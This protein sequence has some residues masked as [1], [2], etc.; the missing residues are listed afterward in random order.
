M[1]LTASSYLKMVFKVTTIGSLSATVFGY[2]YLQYINSVIGSISLNKEEAIAFYKEKY[3][4][5]EKQ[6][7]ATYYYALWNLS[8]ARI[9]EYHTY[10]GY[11]DRLNRKIISYSLQNYQNA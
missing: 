7:K 6:A 1:T 8:I 5:S 3:Q 11:C 9:L 10:V 4:Y 2:A